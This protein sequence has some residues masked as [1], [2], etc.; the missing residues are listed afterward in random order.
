M[1]SPELA[2][3]INFVLAEAVANAV[4]HGNASRVNVSVKQTPNEIQLQIR[5][6][7]VGLSGANGNYNQK[8]LATLG[9]GPQSISKRVTEL[10]G[11]LALSSSPRGVELRI[12][13]ACDGPA[14]K[15][16]KYVA[17]AFG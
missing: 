11:R 7:G 10:R 1:V 9:I 3:Q 14:T 12:D 16:T 4:Q 2:R 6:N 17:H 13:L 5:D 8:E 15:R